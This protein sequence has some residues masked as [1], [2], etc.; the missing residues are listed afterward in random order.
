MLASAISRFELYVCVCV[1]I[2][3][4]GTQVVELGP[5]NVTI[6]KLNEHVSI[7]DLTK[8]RRIYQRV[9]RELT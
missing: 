9:L 2:A 4:T 8:L 6:H 7:A 5:L 3:P 1:Y